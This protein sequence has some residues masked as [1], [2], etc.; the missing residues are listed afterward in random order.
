MTDRQASARE[1][2][3]AAIEVGWYHLSLSTDF[4]V[5]LDDYEASVVEF[6]QA[7]ETCNLHSVQDV[8]LSRFLETRSN[9]L[10]NKSTPRARLRENWENPAKLRY[11][12]EDDG[13]VTVWPAPS[14]S[15]K[16]VALEDFAQA[17]LTSETA[18]AKGLTKDPTDYQQKPFGYGEVE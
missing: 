3:D 1:I 16:A 12:V 15:L 13:W 10:C 11:L 18:L 9:L 5:S 17:L 4:A 6:L 8:P 2:Y 14:E 7:L